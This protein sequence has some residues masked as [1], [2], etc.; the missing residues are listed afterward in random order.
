M[1]VKQDILP[2]VMHHQ[3][4]LALELYN[5]RNVSP[6]LGGI[7]EK[8]LFDISELL[9][10]LVERTEKLKFA[11]NTTSQTKDTIKK[12]YLVRDQVM[13]AMAAIREVID[14]L[15]TIMPKSEWP[16]PTYS[17]ILFYN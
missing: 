8:A 6:A 11:K 7:Q 9:S 5:L 2:A 4:E 13:V 16:Y 1:M 15:E 14:K 12:A 10:Q 3:S 17:D